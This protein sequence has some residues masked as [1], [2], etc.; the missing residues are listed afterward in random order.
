MKSMGTK[1]ISYSSHSKHQAKIR[2]DVALNNSVITLI[3]YSFNKY[4]IS[5][6]A[7]LYMW[8]RRGNK[9]TRKL[10]SLNE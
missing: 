4:Y 3:I 2:K 10:Y 7:E 5:T 9:K 6:M 1:D 8:G